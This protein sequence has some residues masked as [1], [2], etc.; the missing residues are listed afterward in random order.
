[1]VGLAVR[2]FRLCWRC[3][4]HRFFIWA[5]AILLW[6][7]FGRAEVISSLKTN[8]Y[9][10]KGEGFREIRRDL[11]EKR[12]LNKHTNARSDAV[13]QWTISWTYKWKQVDGRYALQN[14]KVTVTVE[15]VLPRWTYGEKPDAEVLARWQSYMKAL[16]AHE[17]DHQQFALQ[18]AKLL[19]RRLSNLPSQDSVKELERLVKESGE[20]ALK[21]C[22]A[23]DARYDAETQNGIKQGARFP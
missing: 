4:S 10:V 16:M 14:P 19:E 7:S 12:P 1:M 18:G 5:L 8:Y 3:L 22:R 11:N 9:E 17:N 20:E 2:L 23:K 6:P 15:M 13:T 21:E